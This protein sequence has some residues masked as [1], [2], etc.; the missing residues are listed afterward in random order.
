MTSSTWY[1][2][3]VPNATDGQMKKLC[4][5]NSS[6]FNIDFISELTARGSATAS[7]GIANISGKTIWTHA[8]TTKSTI[9][10]ST[11]NQ[12]STSHSTTSQSGI[13]TTTALD[14]TIPMRDS[15]GN[16]TV[17]SLQSQYPLCCCASFNFR[18]FTYK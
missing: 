6:Q 11:T 5:P 12:T 2:Y 4:T 13:A 14:I 16:I 3:S 1:H 9:S 7:S 8:T 18:V 10:Q 17:V 15:K